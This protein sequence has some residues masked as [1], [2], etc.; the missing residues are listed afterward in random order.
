[1]IL[2]TF[3]LLVQDVLWGGRLIFQQGRLFFLLVFFLSCIH[4]RLWKGFFSVVLWVQCPLEDVEMLFFLLFFLLFF[5]TPVSTGGCGKHVLLR[6]IRGE[7]FKTFWSLAYLS[8]HLLTVAFVYG[9]SWTECEFLRS[10]PHTH[11]LQSHT[12]YL[13]SPFCMPNL[14]PGLLCR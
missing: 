12:L 14:L 6:V 10:F 9:F 7:I 2:K 1:M 13:N 3:C 11:L 4:W 8:K 5:W